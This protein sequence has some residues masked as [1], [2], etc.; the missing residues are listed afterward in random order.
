MTLA[1]R[2]IHTPE[3]KGFLRARHWAIENTGVRHR[4][5]IEP[6]RFEHQHAELRIKSR[7]IHGDLQLHT[8]HFRKVMEIYR[9]TAKDKAFVQ[10][11]LEDKHSWDEVLQEA[12]FAEQKYNRNAKGLRGMGHRVFRIVGDNA[13]AANPWL[14]ILPDS[15]YTSV[16]CGGL[17]LIFEAAGR[18][19][20]KRQQILE[21]LEDVP[22]TLA[23]IERTLENFNADQ[24]L[25]DLT[26]ELYVRIL[27]AIEGMM[28]WLVDKAGWKQIKALL[29]GPLYEKS[30]DDKIADVKN[31]IGE[32]D[33]RVA[34]LRDSKIIR[35]DETTT[36]TK[37]AVEVIQSGVNRLEERYDQQSAVVDC[38]FNEL[39]SSVDGWNG[40]I[41]LLHQQHIVAEWN[42]KKWQEA[43][44][45]NQILTLRLAHV[46][47]ATNVSKPLIT[48]GNLIGILAVDPGGAMDDIQI[49]MRQ[50]ISLDPSCQGQAYS[51]MRNSK[52]EIWL[53][54]SK[55]QALLVDGNSASVALSRTSP[56]SLLCATLARSLVGVQSAICL[57]FFCGLH[58]S[59]N[60]SLSGPQGLI[61]S[62]T[63][64]LLSYYNF[65]L[66]FINCRSFRDRIQSHEM[67]HL[68]ELFRT[69]LRQIPIDNVVFCIIDSIS[70][71]ERAEWRRDICFVVHK[72]RENTEI[73]ELNAV[74]KLFIASSSRSRHVNSHIAPQ[75]QLI[76]PRDQ[77]GDMQA[78]TPRRLSMQLRRP[79]VNRRS[80]PS[81]TNQRSL[82]MGF[83]NS[84][85]DDTEDDD[86]EAGNLSDTV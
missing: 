37:D 79:L 43:E 5:F 67:H 54:S 24:T 42:Q 41:D 14:N 12:R 84:D 49:T 6:A 44:R 53:K 70:L 73:V 80:T 16:L 1:T 10:F 74:F 75:D 9:C 11:D 63:S 33:S 22:K 46:N 61:R 28:Q 17:K 64:Q 51:L 66:G 32:I 31:Q 15:E 39:K 81:L 68:C 47:T 29:L 36:Q 50:G 8:Q 27:K 59:S 77:G 3:E 83:D 34:F 13:A 45:R 60:D 55:A 25:S 38:K 18:M 78:L 19:S 72:L 86:F 40:L 4:S 57:Q 69:L 21:A 82:A 23:M 48:Q 35:T 58:T 76:L 20:D 71:Y 85:D 52:F 2:S 7:Y 26:V 62:L 65:D 30:L 56:I